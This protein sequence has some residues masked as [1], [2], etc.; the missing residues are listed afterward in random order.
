M[1][2][3]QI[4]GLTTVLAADISG[5]GGNERIRGLMEEHEITEDA[6]RKARLGRRVAEEAREASLYLLEERVHHFR[7]RRDEDVESEGYGEETPHYPS[8]PR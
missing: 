4:G 5:N 2:E 1:G 8:K 6:G 3:K 7:G